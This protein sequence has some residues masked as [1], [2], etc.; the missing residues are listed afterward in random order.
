MNHPAL[1]RRDCSFLQYLLLEESSRMYLYD[2]PR[3]F[4]PR[5][6]AV[7]A[8]KNLVIASENFVI[9]ASTFLVRN[10]RSY[11]YDKRYFPES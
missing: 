9:F 8:S 4:Q 1:A 5:Q 11:L 7:F 3:A 6:S 2:V 10:Y